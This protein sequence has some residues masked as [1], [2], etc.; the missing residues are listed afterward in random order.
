MKEYAD[1]SRMDGRRALNR[2]YSK[3]VILASTPYVFIGERKKDVKN[4]SK[5]LCGSYYGH[6]VTVS[7]EQKQ[8]LPETHKWLGKE[9]VNV[10]EMSYLLIGTSKS[11]VPA[12]YK[13]V[14]RIMTYLVTQMF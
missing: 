7:R 14:N 13:T 10:G 4:T 6:H 2:L 3:S 1:V 5:S 12:T 8:V 9:I 11:N